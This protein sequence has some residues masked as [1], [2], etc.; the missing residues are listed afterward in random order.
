MALLGCAQALPSPA[1]SS[2][3]TLSPAQCAPP[4]KAGYDGPLAAAWGAYK[5]Y[6]RACPIAASGKAPAKLWLLTVFAQPYLD[7][8]PGETAWPDFPRPLLVTADGHCLARLPELFPF[9]EPRSLQLSY[10]PL[11][12]GMP[13]EIRV[14]VSNPAA[15][16]DYDLP[17]L[18]WVPS[19]HAYI[20]QNA[21]DEY[22]KD[23]MTCPI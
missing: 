2:F 10:G 17:L 5:P 14:H 23:D 3:H 16:G 12:D 7:D 6:V 13:N 20:A 22:T 21:T 9:D 11:L 4:A 18:R 1:S 19:Q 8:H 15:G